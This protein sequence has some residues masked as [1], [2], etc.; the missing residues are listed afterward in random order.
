MPTLEAHGIHI[1]YETHGQG[2]PLVFIS[3]VGYSRWFWRYLIPLLI[4][5]YQIITFD[6]RG[7]GETDKPPG[8]YTVAQMAADTAG[9]L[10]ALGLSGVYLF[11]HSLGG[12]IAQELAIQRPD[13]VAKLVLAS[14]NHGGPEAIPVTPEALQ[15]MTDRS[16]TPMD[17]VQRGIQVATAEGFA[18][19][20]PQVVQDL[21]A[22][23]MSNPIPPEAYQAQVMAGAGMGLL[24][25]EEV[26]RRMAALTMPVLILTGDQDRVVPPGNADL[27]KAKIPHAEVRIIPNTGHLFPLEDPETT[28][29]ILREFL[30]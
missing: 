21:V 29:R 24:T 3:G 6:N 5:H 2:H 18:E 16:G 20:K 14:T 23:W 26:S 22:Y 19:R 4:D 1:A 10:D 25:K 13:L 15:A 28:A 7:V 27:L 30:G 12:F 9:L 8:P 17:I 11:G